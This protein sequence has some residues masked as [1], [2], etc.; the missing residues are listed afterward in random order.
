MDKK[1]AKVG[2]TVTYTVVATDNV[3]VDRV[4]IDLKKPQTGNT[5]FDRMTSIGNNMY[6]YQMT[7]TDSSETGEWE[8]ASVLVYDGSENYTRDY[9]KNIGYGTKDYSSAK[10]QI[11]GGLADVEK[12]VIKSVTVDKKTAKVGDTV[13]YTVVA[14]DKVK[15]DRVYIDLKKPQ[16]GN[17]VF[18]RMTSIGNNMYQYQMTV[19]DSSETGEWE[20]ASVLVYD[21]SENY[22]RDYN[23]NIGYGTKDYSSAKVQITG[24]LADVE[25]PVIKSVTVDKKTAKVG[26]TVTYTVVAT[27]NVKIDRVY[28]D[29]KKPQTGNTVF[30]RMTSIGNNMYQYQMTV[31]DSSETGEWEVASVLVYDGSE[32]YTRDYNKNIGYGTKDYSSAT[33]KIGN[34]ITVEQPTTERPTTE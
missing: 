10:V 17:T 21:G 20:V 2:D 9:N 31:T 12:P 22:T 7:V 1:S 27:D 29:L 16:T 4:Y 13:T 33:V 26:D 3:G 28:I 23:K 34:N 19:T 32:N 25:K 30:D 8:V 14:T 5:V 11:T 24:G 6:Q 18:D 15:I